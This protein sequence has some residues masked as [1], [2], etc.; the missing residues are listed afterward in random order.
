MSAHRTLLVLL[1]LVLALPCLAENARYTLFLSAARDGGQGGAAH[2]R[3]DES[4]PLLAWTWRTPPP[5][6]E[7]PAGETAAARPHPLAQAT[8]FGFV[9]PDGTKITA[10]QRQATECECV[11]EVGR[12][13]AELANAARR[14]IA[15]P[16]ATVELRGIA[17]EGEPLVSLSLRGV[18]VKAVTLWGPGFGPRE[19]LLDTPQDR[20]LQTVTLMCAE[21]DLYLGESNWPRE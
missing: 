11:L 12:A 14:G 19:G 8:R 9:L 13:G 4:I 5:Q 1:V 21:T 2:P 6:A 10:S 17:G 15:L 16:A 3:L 18:R 7:V 20:P